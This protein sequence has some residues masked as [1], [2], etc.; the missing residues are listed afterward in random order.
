MLLLSLVPILMVW[1]SIG[2]VNHDIFCPESLFF[3][4]L[5]SWPCGDELS[6]CLCFPSCAGSCTTRKF[7]QDFTKL[8]PIREDHL[9]FTPFSLFLQ[10]KGRAI[11][12]G[13]CLG[14][15]RMCRLTFSKLLQPPVLLSP[16]S[17]TSF[18]CNFGI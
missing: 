15:L 3:A 1:P 16:P 7:P 10:D 9:S 8:S 4:V 2:Q 5:E 13:Q 14:L 6:P 18:C 17:H 12:T 11:P